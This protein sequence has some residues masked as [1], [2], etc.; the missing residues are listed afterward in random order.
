M[1]KK[2]LIK[3][4]S[5]FYFR[6][7]ILRPNKGFTLIEMFL[8]LSITVILGIAVGAF[9]RNIFSSGNYLQ[10]SFRAEDD[11]RKILRDMVSEIRSMNYSGVGGYFIEQASGSS[12]TFYSDING[13]GK[14]E[15]RRYYKDGDT[16]KRGIVYPTGSPINYSSPEKIS[17]VVRDIVNSGNIF[18][19]Y[20]ENYNG[21]GSALSE[22]IDLPLIRLVK[23]DIPIILKNGNA[24]T[25]YDI[26]SQVS[27]RNLKENL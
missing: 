7:S 4:K 18:S 2:N 23:I 14:T 15:R 24:T 1:Q 10:E 8:A 19:Y 3:N 26:E 22:P 17:I 20:D 11:A 21:F 6:F 27:I 13:D 5:I 25:T 9:Q 12:F 16:I